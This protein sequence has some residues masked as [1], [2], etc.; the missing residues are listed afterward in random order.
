MAV[1]TSNDDPVINVRVPREWLARADGL[2]PAL[3]QDEAV[4]SIARPS[5]STVFRLAVLRGIEALE[6]EYGTSTTETAP[7]KPKARKR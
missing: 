1:D 3:A 5:R 2:V 4:R 6:H 7:A